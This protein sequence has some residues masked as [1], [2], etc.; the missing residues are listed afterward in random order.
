MRRWTTGCAL[1]IWVLLSAGALAGQA[2][3]RIYIEPLDKDGGGLRKEMIKLLKD[4]KDVTVVTT[5]PGADRVLSGTN[6]TYIKGYLSRNHR[7]RYR[8]SDSQPVY[9]GYFSV[10]LKDPNDDVVW[11]YLVTPARFGADDINRN[12][13]SQIVN[14]LVEF[15]DTGKKTP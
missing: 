12:L 15:L 10:E 7:V 1:T 14:R 5:E 4:R 3:A 9:G 8:N 6:Q 2:P 11:S 13:A